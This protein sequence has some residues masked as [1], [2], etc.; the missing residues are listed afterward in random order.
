[1]KAGTRLR[2]VVCSTEIIVVR[3]PDE[4]VPI[5]C[6][7]AVMEL[8]GTSPPPGVPDPEYMSGTQLGKRYVNEDI[9]IEVLCTKAGDGSLAIAGKNLVLKQA[10]PLPSSD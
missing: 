1:M 5:E 9:G 3:A 7:G 10:K 8:L 2:S 4:N 6:G